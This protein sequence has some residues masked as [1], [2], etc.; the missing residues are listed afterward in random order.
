MRDARIGVVGETGAAAPSRCALLAERGYRTLRAFAS[1]RS[2]EGED[3]LASATFR[4]R[5]HPATL[6][7]ESLN[8]C[9]SRGGT[10]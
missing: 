4:W 2:A 1:S 8:I 5:K 7:A 10:G 9:F 6:A 3:G